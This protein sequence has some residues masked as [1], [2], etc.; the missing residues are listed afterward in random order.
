ME[1]VPAS[2]TAIPARHRR[3]LGLLFALALLIGAVFAASPAS[4]VP[5]SSEELQFHMLLNQLRASY[6]LAPLSW[7]DALA[8]TSR[9]WSGVMVQN[10]TLMHDPNLAAALNWA[11]PGWTRG[12]ENVGVG[13]DVQSIHDAFVNSG[14][15]LA[16]MVGDYNRVGIGVQRNGGKIFVT[17][18]FARK[19]PDAPGSL[20]TGSFDGVSQTGEGTATASGWAFDPDTTATIDVHVYVNGRWGGSTRASSSR[21]DVGRVFPQYGPDRGWTIQL[22]GL[23]A[24]THQVCAYAINAPGTSGSNPLLACRSVTIRLLGS[25]FGS[26]DSLVQV[27]PGQ[28]L[29]Q[30]WALDPDTTDPISVEVWVDG[31]KRGSALA[32]VS[33]PDVQKVFG[34]G[35]RHGYR[36]VA[37]M[38]SGGSHLVCVRA[39]NAAS[40]PG[41]S[42]NIG[43]TSVTMPSSPIG[44]LDA[45]SSPRSGVVR[46]SGWTLDP[47]VASSIDVHVYVDGRWGTAATANQ[48]RPDVGTVYPAWGPMHGYTVELSVSR[49]AHQVCAFAINAAG[50]AGSNPLLGCRSITVG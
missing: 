5:Q 27:G 2:A 45:V 40:T 16:N 33:R 26:I 38:V 39:L 7:D 9:D 1:P 48:S 19:W 49:G 32:D 21:P 4:A 30:G 10:D 6:G 46:L 3:S 47:E 13:W 31:V 24:G 22:G 43:C 23:P 34:M 14:P 15:H 29:A 42:Q 36:I 11:V 25:P 18:R 41:S 44:S 20:P 17:V 50:T 35:D 28:L 8:Q 12:G 37:T